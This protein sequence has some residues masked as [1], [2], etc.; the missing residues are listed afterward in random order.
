MIVTIFSSI[1]DCDPSPTS[2]C[3]GIGTAL[4][5]GH[6]GPGVLL[7]RAASLVHGPT[8]PWPGHSAAPHCHWQ[9][10]RTGGGPGLSES[11]S[12]SESYAGSASQGGPG[13]VEVTVI[14]KMFNISNP[15][16]VVVASDARDFRDYNMGLGKRKLFR[17]TV[18]WKLVAFGLEEPYMFCI[19]R[20]SK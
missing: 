20:K 7:G 5:S 10:Q 11:D 18:T 4:A 15:P 17:V 9:W 14:P 3:N 6:G 1:S 8:G 16:T 12:D 19:L 2:G 13:G